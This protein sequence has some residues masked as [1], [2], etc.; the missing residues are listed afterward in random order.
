METKSSSFEK[1]S[2][3]AKGRSLGQIVGGGGMES[4]R[5][6]IQKALKLHGITDLEQM[7]DL[8]ETEIGSIKLEIEYFK[9]H[10]EISIEQAAEYFRE[11]GQISFAIADR[12]SEG[13]RSELEK[14]KDELPE[15]KVN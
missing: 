3:E 4:K 1:R 11:K 13:G 2:P 14:M 15:K 5:G 7:N 6:S 10:P 8:T 12:L 9:K